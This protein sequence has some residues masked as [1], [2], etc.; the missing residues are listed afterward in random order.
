MICL[1]PAKRAIRFAGG[2]FLSISDRHRLKNI[3]FLT[4][5]MV[6]GL[7]A[8]ELERADLSLPRIKP[9]PADLQLKVED[10]A[11]AEAMAHYA[12]ALQLES[13][14]KM[15]EALA[16]YV[17]VATADP[18]N[19]TLS[20]HAA[21]LIYHYQSRSDAVSFLEKCIATRPDEPAVYLN[22]VRFLT[23]YVSEDP[24]EKDRGHQIVDQTLT[25]FPRRSDVIVFSV[26]FHLTIAQREEAVK[27]LD[28]ASKLDVR[29]PSWWL[30]LGRVAQ[31][32]WPLAQ[33]ELRDEHTRRVNLFFE[34]ALGHAASSPGGDAARLSVAEYYVL[35][36]QLDAARSLCEKIVASGSGLQARKLLFRLYESSEQP[37]KALELLE[38]IV[39]L[40]PDDVEQRRLLVRAYE[41]REQWARAVPHMEAAIRIGGGDASEYQA[42]GQLLLQSQL[43]EKLIQLCERTTR[44]YPDNP[45]F[46]LHAAFAQRSLQRWEKAI[47]SMERAA[48]MADSGP[49]ELVN[50]RFYFQFGLTLERGDRFDEAG[51]MFEKA[52]TLTPKDEVEDAAN[53]MNY[54]GYMWI[55]QGRH[56]DKAGELIRKANELQPGKAAYI[57]SLGWWH[58]KKGDYGHALVELER[59]FSLITN[60]EPDD[61][62]IIEHIA[63]THLKMGSKAKAREWF[64]K[65]LELKPQEPKVL[66]RIQE[67]LDACR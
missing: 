3:L 66:K 56:L 40:A 44:L 32:V 46:H 51:R 11:I 61:A 31:E 28:Q 53:T 30:D 4:A 5:A 8:A 34:R 55:E 33:T 23:T 16:H 19:A 67:G 43:Y 18:A 27:I 22:L 20:G 39:K 29:E 42:L 25:R 37:D 62:E 59:A 26:Q 47:Q 21:E 14:G 6:C 2:G 52:I 35:T 65:A 7:H 9:P 10:S 24:F 60:P 58:Y 12:T 17:A 54:L 48:A 41:S 13:A 1:R 15:R 50:H 57:D 64:T 63:Q 38:E 49:A 45:V 36:N